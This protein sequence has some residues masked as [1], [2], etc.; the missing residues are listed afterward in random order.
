[1]R[2]RESD[3]RSM[4]VVIICWISWLLFLGVILGCS[5]DPTQQLIRDSDEC[6]K[7]GQRAVMLCSR[8]QHCY[9]ECREPDG[10]RQ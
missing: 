6:Y 10:D 1:M 5:P 9:I 7:R 3:W 2:K 8:A 4:L